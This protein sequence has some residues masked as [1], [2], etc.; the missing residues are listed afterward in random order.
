MEIDWKTF[1][2]IYNR[3]DGNVGLCVGEIRQMSPAQIECVNT[4]L[5]EM[6]KLS[7]IIHAEF[8]TAR[9]LFR[10]A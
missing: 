2:A 10:K 3:K 9:T 7:D 6:K 8:E 4:A 5:A 1:N